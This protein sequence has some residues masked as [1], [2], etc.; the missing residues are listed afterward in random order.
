MLNRRHF[1]RL[2]GAG[3][4]AAPAL[5]HARPGEMDAALLQRACETLHPGLYRYARPAQVAARFAG[6]F[7]A[8][9]DLPSKYLALSRMLGTV[10]CGHSYANFYNQRRAVAAALFAGRNRLPFRF[11]WLG[12]RMIVTADTER[13]GIVPGTEI[14]A[15]DGRASAAILAA[16]LRLA[17]ADGGNDAKRRALLEVNGI[18][19]YEAFD[20][21]FPLLFPMRGGDYT[22]DLRTPAGVHREVRVGPIDLARR[23]TTMR[24]APDPAPADNPGWR[25]E[26]DGA[27]AIMTMPTWALYDSTWNWRAWLTAA[28]EDLGRRGT[29]ALILDLRDNEGG[30]D[31]GRHVLSRLIDS[32]LP[33]ASYERRVRFREA[34]RDLIQHLDTWDRSFDRLGVEALELG[35]GFYRLPEDDGEA[36]IRPEGPRFRGQL[37]VLI[38]AQN[39]SAT[40]QFAEA[41]RA[42]RLGRLVGS[43]TGGN[44]RGINGGSFY[45]LRL[46][47]S[48]LEADL[49]LVGTFPRTPQPD[50][51]L[52]PDI[53]VGETPADIAAGRD[54]GLAAALALVRS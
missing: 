38:G 31:C 53:A 37:I 39:S 35:N 34:P 43:T 52:E 2:A 20:I 33:L 47:E 50:A 18:D 40:F 49:P 15:V 23:R 5:L 17:R 19:A 6:E 46:P 13:N 29:T 22:L 4:C 21:Y 32:P 16:L 1:I 3:V 41:V 54:A 7:G 24:V 11:R 26:H 8:A 42:G 51:G 36:I 27:A 45:F 30:Q 28:F 14:L 12:S 48:G 9:R 25:L 44:R 10:R